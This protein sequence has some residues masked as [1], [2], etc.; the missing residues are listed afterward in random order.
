MIKYITY[1]SVTALLFD[2]TNPGKTVLL[3]FQAA[4]ELLVKMQILW[5]HENSQ[6][7]V[8]AQLSGGEHF[9]LHF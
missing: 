9:N 2:D 3:K 5:V 1:L 8:L 7:L 6:T 4:L